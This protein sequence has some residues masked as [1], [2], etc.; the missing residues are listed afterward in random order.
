MISIKNN[1]QQN[2]AGLTLAKLFQD[3]SVDISVRIINMTFE[4]QNFIERLK[5]LYNTALRRVW[6][7]PRPP[8]YIASIAL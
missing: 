1:E 3:L 5:E 7:A 6:G 4:G 2:P 8:D